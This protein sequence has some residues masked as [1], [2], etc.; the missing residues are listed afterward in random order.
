MKIDQYYRDSANINLNGS[1]ASLLPAA[2]IT[3]GNL[4]FF[5]HKEIM[6]LTIPFIIYSLI[7]FQVYLFRIRQSSLIR[8]N[9]GDSQ[10]SFQCLFESR[11][12]LVVFLASKLFLYV[13]EGHQ[14]GVIKRIRRR[15]VRRLSFTKIYALYNMERQIIAY[16]IIKKRSQ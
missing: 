10:P 9:L 2:L 11:Y 1:I 6:L 15:G 4:F 3:G 14:A 5:H 8:D 12:F 16:F 7:A 13:P